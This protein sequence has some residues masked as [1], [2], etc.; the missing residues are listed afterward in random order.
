VRAEVFAQNLE[1]IIVRLRETTDAPV[2]VMN[3]PDLSLSP[4]VPAYMRTNLRRHVVLYNDRIAAIANRHGL[5]IVDLYRASPDFSSH[6]EFFSKDG[7][8]PSDEGYEAWANLLCR[9][10]AECGFRIAD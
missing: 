10:I 3:V 5:R 4:A 9:E 1:E 6:P 7:A 2:F 8:H